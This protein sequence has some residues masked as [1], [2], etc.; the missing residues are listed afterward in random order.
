MTTRKLLILG[1]TGGT[2]FHLVTQ[3]LDAGHDVTAFVR[4]AS[5]IPIQHER[6][7]LIEG[8]VIDDRLRLAE[9]VRG[10]DALISALGRGASFKSAGLIRQSVP[11]II[12]AMQLGG[13]RRLIM[14][15]AI[16]VG[17]AFADAPLFSK[18]L[19]RLFLRDIYADKA[20]GED[21]IRNSGLDWT[22][23]QPAQLTDGPLTGTYQAGEDLKHGGIPRISRADVAHFI[24]GQLDD[25]KCVGKTVRIGY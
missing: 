24:L 22:I 3:A 11:G 7:R 13:V 20:A 8:S 5:S 10:R 25:T 18:A 15:S 19:I 23:V 4:I 1:A 12:A 9:A 21:L 2:G 6:L 14:M 17:P 16:G